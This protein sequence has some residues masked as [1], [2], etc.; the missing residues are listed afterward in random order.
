MS[1]FRELLAQ[2][3]AAITEISTSEAE[4]RLTSAAFLDV[5]E[6][7]EFEQGMIP[8]S[9][10]IPRGH[11]E[12][13][14]ENRLPDRDA[15]IVVYCAGGV[16]SAF[17]TETLVRLVRE[18][19]A[20]AVL[21]LEHLRQAVQQG[22]ELGQQRAAADLVV[23]AELLQG[24][25]AVAVEVEREGAVRLYYRPPYLDLGVL[26]FLGGLALLMGLV[27]TMIFVTPPGS[28]AEVRPWPGQAL[29][30]VGHEAPV[31]PIG[32]GHVHP[33]FRRRAGLPAHQGQHSSCSPDPPRGIGILT[34]RPRG[35]ARG[36]A[37][38]AWRR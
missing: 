28:A 31:G 7:D 5:R 4:S 15:E 26:A 6:L 11:L 16:R 25:G 36:A 20:V 2:S 8:G 33:G 35:T 23:A 34:A 14:A 1:S 17:A 37:R 24:V 27:Q 12:A 18:R 3:R 13:Q 10:F 21:E 29:D 9:V 38:G 22:A 30:H 19:G 32:L